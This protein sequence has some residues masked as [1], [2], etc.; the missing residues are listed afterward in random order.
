MSFGLLH[1]APLIKEFLERHPGITLD[2]NMDDRVSNLV[3]AGVDM[4]IRAGILPDSAL[5]ARKLAPIHSVLAASPEYLS[6]AGTPRYPEDLLQHSCLHYSYSRD[7]REWTL[8]GPNDE[9]S[10][11]TKGKMRVNNSQ[12]L[13]TALIDGQGI[14]RL[15]TFVAS[16]HLAAGRLVRVLPAYSLPEQ[17]LYAVFPERRHMPAKVRAFADFLAERIGGDT[18]YWDIEA[19]VGG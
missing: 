11:R 14:G 12:A 19:G 13:C 4:A 18:P 1:V 16:P 7:A 8:C 17:S 10:V 2:L 15:P 9:L 5:I 6:Q 3:E